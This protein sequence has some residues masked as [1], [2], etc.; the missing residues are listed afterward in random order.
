MNKDET[1]KKLS[2][3]EADDTEVAHIEADELLLQFL[4]DCGHQDVAEAYMAVKS[5]CNGFWYA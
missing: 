4:F 1:I 3:V 5:R 2:A